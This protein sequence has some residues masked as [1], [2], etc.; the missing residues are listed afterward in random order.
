MARAN[1][2]SRLESR[3]A[4][5]SLARSITLKTAPATMKRRAATA[6]A[7]A[8]ATASLPETKNAAHRS[9]QSTICTAAR[10]VVDREFKGEA[11]QGA[12]APGS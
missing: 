8:S 3:K 9:V 10:W 5:G 1:S 2:Q 7:P 6:S 4:L 12:I 11:F